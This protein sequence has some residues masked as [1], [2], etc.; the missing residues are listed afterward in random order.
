MSAPKLVLHPQAHDL[1]PS[2]EAIALALHNIGLI[3]AA[4]SLDGNTH[5]QTGPDFLDGISFLGCAPSIQLDPPAQQITHA[6]RSGQ[7]CHIHIPAV[8]E[9]PRLRCRIG[10]GPRCRRCR[11]DIPP[12]LILVPSALIACPD[13]GHISPAAGLNWRQSGGYARVY[14]DIWGIHTGEAV[15]SDR[16][17][18][19]LAVASGVPWRFFYI[20]D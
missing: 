17:L 12:H 4:F 10:Q 18:D 16:L 14:L 7:F 5:F 2:R 3:G 19:R 11:V 6:A 20:E 15:P 9:Q 13:C 1:A 8:T